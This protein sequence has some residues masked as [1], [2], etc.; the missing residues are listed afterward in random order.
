MKPYALFEGTQWK[1]T[2]SNSKVIHIVPLYEVYFMHWKIIVELSMASIDWFTDAK[3]SVV[4]SFTKRVIELKQQHLSNMDFEGLVNMDKSEFLP[5]GT[6]KQ[7]LLDPANGIDSD[8][9]ETIAE[10]T[11]INSAT[12][13][14][15]TAEPAEV[16][17]PVCDSAEKQVK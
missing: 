5:L 8:I 4:I 2:K 12:T 16:N 10:N 14:N 1:V 9:A 15:T 7:E 13:N 11:G 17:N 6:V 3:N